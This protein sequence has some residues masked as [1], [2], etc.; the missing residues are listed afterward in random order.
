MNDDTVIEFKDVFF[1]YNNHMVLENASCSVNNRD[2]VSL[3]G[4]NGGGKTT[5]LKLI[6]GLLTPVKGTINIF[7]KN[8]DKDKMR[9][10]YVPQYNKFDSKFPLTL[11]DVV[12]SGTLNSKYGLYS[13]SKKQTAFKALEFVDLSEKWSSSFH[14][15]SGGQKQRVIL[16]RAIA[17]NPD[18]L[19]LDEPLANIDPENSKKI[20]GLL[21]KLNSEMTILLATHDYSF[22]SSISKRVF[23][24]LR[25]FI[26]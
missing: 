20:I 11:Q 26:L 12:L 8:T 24:P 5:F 13:E 2:F 23:S 4:P 14:E 10:G 1:S 15:L 17:S 6:A 22:V 16:A 19:L 18:L 25:T 7:G 21:A 9:I 3:V